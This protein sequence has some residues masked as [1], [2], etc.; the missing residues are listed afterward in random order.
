MVPRYRRIQNANIY[1]RITPE[2]VGPVPELKALTSTRATTHDNSDAGQ[3][4]HLGW[5]RRR[6]SQ[7][8]A[9]APPDSG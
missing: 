7:Q 9:I 4:T 2:P 6:C 1:S 3:A 5:F 8:Q